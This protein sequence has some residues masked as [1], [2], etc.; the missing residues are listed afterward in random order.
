[1]KVMNRFGL[2]ITGI[3]VLTLAAIAGVYTFW[4]AKAKPITKSNDTKQLQQDVKNSPKIA[5][6]ER[7]SQEDAPVVSAEELASELPQPGQQQKVFIDPRTGRSYPEQ[8][9]KPP[10]QLF[11]TPGPHHE[12]YAMNAKKADSPYL[13]AADTEKTGELPPEQTNRAGSTEFLNSLKSKKPAER[14]V[15]NP[16][17]G[18]ELKI[19]EEQ[20][21]QMNE[22]ALLHILDEYKDRPDQ[23]EQIRKIM[24]ERLEHFNKPP[25][26]N[27]IETSEK[28]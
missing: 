21:R 17:E 28:K 9:P 18:A 25:D 20:L 22:T 10:P 7:V 16:P 13:N 24:L 14:S 1:M 2:K 15:P 12:Q 11:E 3:V 23:A 27:A 6:Y 4:P 5:R 26:A 8:T 19:P